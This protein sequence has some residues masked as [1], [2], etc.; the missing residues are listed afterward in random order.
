M[1]VQEVPGRLKK[2]KQSRVKND[3][4]DLLEEGLEK[5]EEKITPK[6]KKVAC[7][8]S[9]GM[10]TSVKTLDREPVPGHINENFLA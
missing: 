8:I 7:N 9:K 6:Y 5:Q 2:T 10:K 3:V 4:L 1:T